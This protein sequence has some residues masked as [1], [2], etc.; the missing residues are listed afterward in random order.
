MDESTRA[1]PLPVVP[2]GIPAALRRRPQWVGW[3]LRPNPSGGKPKKVP[4]DPRKGREARVNDSRSAGPFAAALRLYRDGAADGVGF[5]LTPADPF[6]GVDLDGCRDPATGGL[7][8]WAAGL[9]S[10]LDTYAEASPSGTGVRLFARGKPAADGPKRKGGVELYGSGRFLTVTGHRL[11]GT[12]AGVEDRPDA[13]RQLQQ[14]LAPPREPAALAVKGAT[15]GLP[16]ERLLTLARA[17]GNGAKFTRLWTGDLT[18]YASPSDADLALANILLFWAGGDADQADR[19]FRLSGLMRPK[20]DEKRGR[21]T[22]GRLTLGTAGRGLLGVYR[23]GSGCEG[24][25]GGQGS[26]PTPWSI[27][28]AHLARRFDRPSPDPVPG[29]A[30]A[31]AADCPDWAELVGRCGGEPAALLAAVGRGF[32]QLRGGQFFLSCRTAGRLVGAGPSWAGEL[33]RRL[34]DRRVFE[35]RTQGEFA[36]GRASEYVFQG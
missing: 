7:A 15:S 13:V 5:L 10:H 2:D 36:A 4:L 21:A 19:L 8:D 17:A 1:R 9:V 24:G 31:I 14:S 22:Y 28:C 18:G 30:R 34:V 32:G 16:D 35:L 3:R 33:L 12:A 27:L 26:P 23:P 25:H 20:W 6:A 29:L 11:P